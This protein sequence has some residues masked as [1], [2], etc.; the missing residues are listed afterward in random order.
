MARGRIISKTISSSQKFAAL[1][2]RAGKLAEFCQ[3]LFPL[4]VVHADDFGRL[5]GDPFTVK[6]QVLPISP[7]KLPE[8]QAALE[9]MHDVG[10]IA[11]YEVDGRNYV[12]VHNFDQHQANLHKRTKSKFPEPPNVSRKFREI[13]SELNRTELKGIEENGIEPSAAASTSSPGRN[14][15]ERIVSGLRGHVSEHSIT[16]W[17]SPCWLQEQRAD[18]LVI[19]VPSDVKR[20]YL[21]QN[22]AKIIEDVRFELGI[23]QRV[24]FSS[25]T[26]ARPDALR[27]SSRA[28]EQSQ[29]PR[30]SVT[31]LSW[32][33]GGHVQGFCDW[34]CFPA[35]LF[36]QFARRIEQQKRLDT[37]AARTWVQRWAEGVRKSG[38]VP[39][40][41]MYDFWNG[42][43]DRTHGQATEAS[44]D[45]YAQRVIEES[46]ARRESVRR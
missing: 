10:L 38:V 43:W 31:P 46:K 23:E 26:A 11:W 22:F 2:D 15:W 14:A 12:Q 29:A 34:M 30:N 17:F 18:V 5:Q 37:R 9:A 7:R 21:I 3:T 45:D 39:T 25:A 6:H 1:Y 4:I 28:P 13:P 35:D 41:K 42:Q 8:F 32:K 16:N 40:G 20:D 27:G 36:E 33:H 19:G 44:S 24:Q